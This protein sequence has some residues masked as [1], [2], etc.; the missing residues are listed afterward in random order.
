MIGATSAGFSLAFIPSALLTATP[1]QAMAEKLFEPTIWYSIAPTGEISVNITK[2]E[3]GQHVGT[4]LAR[5][6]AEE[7][8]AD[9][10]DI[11]INHVDTEAKYGLFVTGGSWSVWQNFDLL[12]RAGAAG[13]ASLIEEGAKLLGEKPSACKAENSYVIGNGKR[14]SFGDIV[15]VS[16]THLTLPTTPYV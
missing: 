11:R 14:I 13:R 3:M 8:E 12:S 4:A 9:W 1:A 10:A 2:A 7:L 6:I 5:I 16:Y 15:A